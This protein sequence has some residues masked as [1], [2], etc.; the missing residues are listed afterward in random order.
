MNV[1]VY[2]NSGTLK[3]RDLKFVSKVNVLIQIFYKHLAV[4]RTHAT[5]GRA[6]TGQLPPKFWKTCLLVRYI[7]LQPFPPLRKYMIVPLLTNAEN[8][9][10]PGPALAVAGPNARPRRGTP[11]SSDFMTSSC[12]VNRV[13]IVVD[14]RYTVR[15]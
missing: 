12:S 7:R 1:V 5:L 11:L 10:L 2:Y 14:R 3:K 13:T 15:H 8:K 9:L 6:T 4:K